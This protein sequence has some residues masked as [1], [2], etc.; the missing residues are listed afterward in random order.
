MIPAYL[1]GKSAAQIVDEMNERFWNNV[2]YCGGKV[3]DDYKPMLNGL[4]LLA[5]KDALMNA[6]E[7]NELVEKGEYQARQ[8]AIVFLNTVLPYE[9]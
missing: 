2:Q 1:K 3:K 7:V 8:R 9:E 6:D 5:V 4:L